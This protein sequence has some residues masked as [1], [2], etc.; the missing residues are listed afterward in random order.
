MQRKP[1]FDALTMSSSDYRVAR[2]H[3]ADQIALVA[4]LTPGS[5]AHRNATNV[6]L[7]M[8]DG[9]ALLAQTRALVKRAN[10]LGSRKG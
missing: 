4:T 3:I 5:V 7:L 6:L 1:P 9:L 8:Q 10:A 2:S